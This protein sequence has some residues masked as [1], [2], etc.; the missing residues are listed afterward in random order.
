MMNL[1]V[2][3]KYHNQLMTDAEVLAISNGQ[4]SK[5]CSAARNAGCCTHCAELDNRPLVNGYLSPMQDGDK[6]RYE[7]FEVYD[8]LSR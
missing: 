5:D 6:I 7:T 8:M 4:F 1:F 2:G 3:G